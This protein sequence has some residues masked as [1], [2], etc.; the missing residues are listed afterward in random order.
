MLQQS[1]LEQSQETQT[2]DNT[3]VCKNHVSWT[4]FSNYT[5]NYIKDSILHDV[6]SASLTH[7]LPAI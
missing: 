6:K 4:F 7:S 1:N 3:A 2:S 5:L